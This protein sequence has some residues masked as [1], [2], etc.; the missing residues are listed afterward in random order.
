MCSCWGPP[1][2]RKWDFLNWG[3]SS[4]SNLKRQ[5]ELYS[6]RIPRLEVGSGEKVSERSS[7]R[8]TMKRINTVYGAHWTWQCSRA[9][10]TSFNPTIT[11]QGSWQF[12][13]PFYSWGNGKAERVSNLPKGV[14]PVSSTGR[15]PKRTRWRWSPHAEPWTCLQGPFP[16]DFLVNWSSPAW[17]PLLLPLR[18]ALPCCTVLSVLLLEPPHSCLLY[19]AL[20]LHR[21]LCFNRTRT[22]FSSSHW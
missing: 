15:R 21:S 11:L 9:L 13:S 4:S 7:L 1:G 19:C 6:M 22:Q 5:D 10:L 12:S 3:S 20:S 16:S 18:Q 2:D 8:K 17:A 14:Q